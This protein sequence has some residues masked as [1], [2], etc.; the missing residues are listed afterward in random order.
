ML[1]ELK[2]KIKAAMPGAVKA[3]ISMGGSLML[4][5]VAVEIVGRSISSSNEGKILLAIL[6]GKYLYSQIQ[7]LMDKLLRR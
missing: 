7:K 2:E 3:T 6:A 5:G 4:C 1:S